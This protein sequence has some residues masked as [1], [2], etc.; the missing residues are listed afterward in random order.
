MRKK[1]LF[2]L[3]TIIAVFSALA[4]CGNK[5]SSVE[6]KD[7][8][9][10]IS[11]DEIPGDYTREMAQ[12]DGCIIM[13]SGFLLFGYEKQFSQSSRL[14]AGEE[15]WEKFLDL[16]EQ[17]EDAKVR[18]YY[19]GRADSEQEEPGHRI[20]DLSYKDEKYTLS[21]EEEGEMVT[22]E[23]D[24]LKCYEGDYHQQEWFLTGKNFQDKDYSFLLRDIY[25]SRA[26]IFEDYVPGEP[27][28][29]LIY[30]SDAG[31]ENGEESRRSEK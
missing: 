23:Y 7:L 8:P 27:T 21:F 18:I 22:E 4:A 19:A 11:Y 24:A 10:Y 16:K 13:E 15:L 12:E 6:D 17:G 3:F 2:L 28:W 9:D 30:V 1:A 26:N 25:S 29:K 31:E 20:L 14:V 5:K